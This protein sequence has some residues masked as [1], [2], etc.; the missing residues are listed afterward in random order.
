MFSLPLPI[1]FPASMPHSATHSLP[2]SPLVFLML[3]TSSSH[4]PARAFYSGTDTHVRVGCALARLH[5]CALVDY[6]HWRAHEHTYTHRGAAQTSTTC[7][8]ILLS[9]NS[10]QKKQ[11]MTNAA[12]RLTPTPPSYF[13]PTHSIS[14]APPP[15]S[16]SI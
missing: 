8:T 4:S 10:R 11:S 6:A 3:L 15:F 13:I 7:T 16:P 9:L 12:V 14:H 2:P 1:R 5:T